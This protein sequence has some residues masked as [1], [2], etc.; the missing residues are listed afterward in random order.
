MKTYLTILTICFM[1][2]TGSIFAQCPTGDITFNSQQEV[3]NF[4]SN[5]PNCSELNR[6]L[7]ITNSVTNLNSLNQI[8]SI[9][10]SLVVEKNADLNNFLGLENLNYIGR[11]FSVDSSALISFQGL[12]NLDSIGHSLY[13][14]FLDGLTSLSGLENLNFIGNQL[15]VGSNPNLISLSGLEN[16][17]FAG[18]LSIWLNDNLASLSS[19]E[20]LNLVGGQLWI[21]GNQS[22]T[23]L[24]GLENLDSIVGDLVI[25]DNYNLSDLSDLEKF[26]S[27]GGNLWIR[28]NV[29]LT[30][31]SGLENLDS[32][33][34]D[35]W[36]WANDNLIDVSN[37]I[38][39]NS[40]GGDL[41]IRINNNLTNLSGLENI[42]HTSITDLAITNNPKLSL[43]GIKSICNYLVNGGNA[44]IDNNVEGCNTVEE[45]IQSCADVWDYAVE[46]NI[47]M[48]ENDNCLKDATELDLSGWL[49]EVKG[50]STHYAYTYDDGAYVTPVD[51]GT[52][53]VRA[54]PPNTLWENTCP[55]EVI[56][57][58]TDSNPRDTIDFA[59]SSTIFCP[60]L[61]IDITAPFVRRCFDSNYYVRYCNSGTAVAENAYVEVQLDPFFTYQSSTIA[62]TDLGDNLYSFDLGNINIGDCGNFR[63]DVYV[64]CDSTELGQTHCVEA[65]IFPDSICSPA[66]PLWDGSSIEVDAQCLGDSIEFIIENTGTGDMSDSLE[67]IIVEDNL[68]FIRAKFQLNSGDNQTFYQASTGAFYRLEAEQAPGHPG[69]SMPSVFVEGCGANDDGEISMGFVNYF[70]LDEGNAFVSIDCQENIGSYDPN[71]KQAF[72]V[73][74]GDQHYITDSTDLEYMIRF[75]NTGTDTAFNIVIRDTLSVYLDI[76]TLRPGVASHPYRYDIEASNVAVFHF[77]N[78]M[79]PDSNVNEAASH[80]FIKFNIAQRE[81]NAIGT[82]I[83]NDAAIYFDFNEPIITN[84]VLHTVGQDFVGLVTSVTTPPEVEEAGISVNVFPNPFDE[85]TRFEVKG[86]TSNELNLS[87]YDT[88]GRQVLQQQSTFQQYINLYKNNLPSGIYV[89]KI[90]DEKQQLATGKLMVK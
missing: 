19:L 30:D 29:N 57:N 21:N 44:S 68:I 54:I 46:G 69:S 1:L 33:G 40:I 82:H 59:A 70:L 18:H 8:T 10:R 15:Y 83:T 25:Q 71:D 56:V 41:W 76:E 12:E 85:Y 24:S 65:H 81:N 37:L 48:D 5:Y 22:L 66:L 34:G 61:E 13:I 6:N 11:N 14:G 9:G 4:P 50:A 36:I 28:G 84:K 78:I 62:G 3:D 86:T 58:I 64:D 87:L 39:L 63:I 60:L 2:L 52:F 73:G 72:P 90:T 74:Y 55:E 38:N 80:G 75:Q 7:V 43:C 49:V 79:L 67:Y 88:M 47:F 53:T 26:N 27:V 16:L 77:D 23:D 89:F 45:I 32:I 51:T 31:L 17:N 35:L 20:N 42:D